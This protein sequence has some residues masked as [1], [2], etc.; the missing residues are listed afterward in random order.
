M[1]EGILRPG[2]PRFFRQNVLKLA[3]FNAFGVRRAKPPPRL[4]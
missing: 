4:H 2:F 1:L 3:E